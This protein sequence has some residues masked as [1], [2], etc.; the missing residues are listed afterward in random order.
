[1]QNYHNVIDYS[2]RYTLHPPDSF[3]TANS[4]YESPSPVSL[5]SPMPPLCMSRPPLCSLY[6]GLSLFGIHLFIFWKILYVSKITLF[7]LS[8]SDLFYWAEYP[9]GP[10]ML[11]QMARFHFFFNSWVIVHYI[12]IT[13]LSIHLFVGL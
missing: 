8:L 13:S 6:L 5:I 7:C 3:V 2:S 1:M 11:S 10:S 9:L 4:Y 12:Y